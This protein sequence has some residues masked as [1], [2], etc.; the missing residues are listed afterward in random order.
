MVKRLAGKTGSTGHRGTT[1]SRGPQG[2]AGPTGHRG[3]IGK[4]GRTG[5]A[6]QTEPLHSENMAER[7]V[8]YFDDVYEQLGVQMK[9]IAKLQQEVD[10]MRTQVKAIARQ[11]AAPVRGQR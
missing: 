2:P 5:A 3:K 6:A 4:T 10:D 1:G 11:Q 8:T 9:R 7:L